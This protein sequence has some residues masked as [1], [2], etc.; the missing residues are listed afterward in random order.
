MYVFFDFHKV[1]VSI[2]FEQKSIGYNQLILL[3]TKT[4]H[5]I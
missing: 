4:S 5:S 1:K 3:S 2:F